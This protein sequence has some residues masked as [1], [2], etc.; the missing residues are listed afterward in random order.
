MKNQLIIFSKN[1]P[2]QLHLLLESIYKNGSNLFDMISVL[3]KADND[4]ISGYEKCKKHFNNVIFKNEEH[5]KNDLLNLIDISFYAT[6]F[7][8]D[9]AVMYKEITESKDSILSTINNELDS[10]CFSLRLGNNCTYSHPTNLYYALSDHEINGSIL[11]FNYSDQQG[12]FGYPLSTDGHIFKTNLIYGLLIDIPFK[13]P[14]TLEANLQRYVNSKVLPFD[15]YCFEESKVVS[16]P[17]NLVND[18]FQNRHALMY[19]FA[20]KDLND[21]YLKNEI[22]DLEAMDFTNI[23]GPHKEIEY[24]F[25]NGNN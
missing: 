2:P 18:T 12:D 23:D 22:I 10:V 1:R 14:N 3:Y 4:F 21:R 6:T 17:V 19:H 24:K 15:M 13:N 8:V 11:S 9:D 16:I 25:K 5:F 7:L 20:E